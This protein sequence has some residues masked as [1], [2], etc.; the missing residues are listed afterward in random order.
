MDEKP[1]YLTKAAEEHSRRKA[2]LQEI[3]DARKDYNKVGADPYVLA[4]IDALALA[5]AY[6]MEETR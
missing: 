1:R 3:L 5:T 4:M 2:M 6:L